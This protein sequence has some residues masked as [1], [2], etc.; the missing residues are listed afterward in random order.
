MVYK[1]LVM[2][3]IMGWR[4]RPDPLH[5]RQP[6]TGKLFDKCA[7]RQLQSALHRFISDAPRRSEESGG[8]QPQLWPA[9][10]TV[11]R[12]ERDGDFP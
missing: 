5:L 12:R 2:S 3:F 11:V 8:R 1:S 7:S 10:H 9:M 4:V 6:W